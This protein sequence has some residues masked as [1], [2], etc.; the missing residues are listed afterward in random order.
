MSKPDTKRGNGRQGTARLGVSRRIALL[1]LL[2]FVLTGGYMFQRHMSLELVWRQTR[3]EA[4]LRVLVEERDRVQAE[5]QQLAGFGRLD[6]IW[7]SAGR[8]R[9]SGYDGIAEAHIAPDTV[10]IARTLLSHIQ[11]S[12][13]I[14]IADRR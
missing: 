9:A 1:V 11:R 10:R 7:T 12:R 4:E 13:P 3:Q 2:V 8:P 14:D 6:S 5:L